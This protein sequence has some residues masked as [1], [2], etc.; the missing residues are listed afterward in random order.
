[1]QNIFPK[2]PFLLVKASLGNLAGSYRTLLKYTRSHL[3]IIIVSGE[4]EILEIKRIARVRT[5]LKTKNQRRVSKFP[6]FCFQYE[7]SEVNSNYYYTVS[8]YK[9]HFNP[10]GKE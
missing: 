3:P 1:M 4:E 5:F 6:I 10:I 9:E 8:Y 7:H 2:Q